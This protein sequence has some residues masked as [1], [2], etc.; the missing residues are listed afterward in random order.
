MKKKTFG[1]RYIQAGTTHSEGPARQNDRAAEQRLIDELAEQ[2]RTGGQR[3]QVE[4][5]QQT[6][7]WWEK[8]YWRVFGDT[9]S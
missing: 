1:R 2:A 6:A 8:N 3:E 7:E 5:E 9:S 4:L